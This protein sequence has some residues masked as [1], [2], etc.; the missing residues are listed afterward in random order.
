MLN[1][2]KDCYNNIQKYFFPANIKTQTTNF[3]RLQFFFQRI[4]TKYFGV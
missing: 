4:G 1:R 2:N 3:L